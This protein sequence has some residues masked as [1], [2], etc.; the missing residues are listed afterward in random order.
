MV[1]DKKIADF[2]DA[3]SL[4]VSSIVTFLHILERLILDGFDALRMLHS[5]ESR[6]GIL[7]VLL[8]CGRFFLLSLLVTAV[9][10]LLELVGLF[11]IFLFLSGF[12]L[13]SLVHL[14]EEVQYRVHLIAG[15]RRL[16][17]L[18][19]LLCELG[20]CLRFECDLL[21][22]QF[23]ELSHGFTGRFFGSLDLLSQLP[24]HLAQA[25][26]GLRGGVG[27]SLDVFAERVNAGLLEDGLAERHVGQL[28]CQ[29]GLDLLILGFLLEALDLLFTFLLIGLSI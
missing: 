12:L 21:D 9:H 14:V 2:G 13:F 29:V 22:G 5:H 25:L 26:S 7:K 18:G 1:K 20:L 4:V 27:I 19:L 16:G 24:L 10:S 11:L 23:V 17:F 28:R 15:L 8:D 3:V 6:D